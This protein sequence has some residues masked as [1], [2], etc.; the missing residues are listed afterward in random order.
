LPGGDRGRHKT[1]QI[2]SRQRDNRN[3]GSADL[4]PCSTRFNS[5]FD[6]FNSL[7][8]RLGNLPVVLTKKNGLTGAIGPVKASR[9]GFCQYFPVDQGTGRRI[10]LT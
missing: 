7:F 6:R 8:G 2:G 1:A 10:Q 4:I 9:T 5:L 3:P